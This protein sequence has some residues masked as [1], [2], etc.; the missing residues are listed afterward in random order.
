[1]FLWCYIT[2][3]FDSD[4]QLQ[5]GHL[6]EANVNILTFESANYGFK[7]ECFRRHP[8]ATWRTDL[9]VTDFFHDIFCFVYIII[10]LFFLRVLITALLF[11]L[12]FTSY[13]T[14]SVNLNDSSILLSH[15]LLLLYFI[16]LNTFPV[17][18]RFFIFFLLKCKLLL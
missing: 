5:I 3:Y 4:I 13:R 12:M 2:S 6:F 9:Q 10:C 16:F 1:M 15:S 18:L 11:K 14:L 17:C 7:L 8:L